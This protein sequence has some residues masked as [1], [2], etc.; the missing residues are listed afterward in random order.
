MPEKITSQT[1][2]FLETVYRLEQRDGVARTSEIVKMLKVVPGTVTNTVERLEKRGFVKHEAYKGVVLTQKGRR[3]ALRVIRKHRLSE[4]LLSDI[5]HIEWNK[6]HEAACQ[7]EHGLTE[8]V[9]KNIEKVLKW[10]RTCPHGNPI[11]TRCGGIIEELQAKPLLN[12][13]QGEEGTVVMITDERSSILKRVEMLGLKPGA[14]VKM[15]K[16]T[17]RGSP[18][19]VR[20]DEVRRKVPP[21]L[22]VAVKV[23]KKGEDSRV[24]SGVEGWDIREEFH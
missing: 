21:E 23:K 16:K 7:L 17:Q 1:E 14:H 3:I 20:V 4:R 18:I 12:L 10:P 2:E 15:L 11:P 22:A 8:E 19:Y 5:L 13:N 6:V 24:S 9:A